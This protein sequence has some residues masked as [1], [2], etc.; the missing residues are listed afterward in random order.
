MVI[1]YAIVVSD[2]VRLRHAY[3]VPSSRAAAAGRRPTGSLMCETCAGSGNDLERVDTTQDVP[4][5]LTGANS[6]S[7]YEVPGSLM[8]SPG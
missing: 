2:F 4:D 7:N 8:T 6:V 3:P 5:L 1:T